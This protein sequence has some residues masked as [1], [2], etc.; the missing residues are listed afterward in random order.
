MVDFYSAV[1]AAFTQSTEW[2]PN[3]ILKSQVGFRTWAPLTLVHT[4]NGTVTSLHRGEMVQ[5]IHT[6]EKQKYT[7]VPGGCS[8]LTGYITRWL[9]LTIVLHRSCRPTMPKCMFTCHSFVRELRLVTLS[10]RRVNK[11]GTLMMML[12]IQEWDGVFRAHLGQVL[13]GFVGQM[14]YTLLRQRCYRFTD[15]R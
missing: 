9:L 14:L 5:S 15:I 10:L 13:H 2:F 12:Y 7:H 4:G 11:I 3:S 1:V 6:W 8:L